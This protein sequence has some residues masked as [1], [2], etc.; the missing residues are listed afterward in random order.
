MLE[1]P[2]DVIKNSCRVFVYTRL[3]IYFNI[4]IFIFIVTGGTD[5]RPKEQ[6]PNRG[7]DPFDNGPTHHVPVKPT[8]PSSGNS[9]NVLI[10]NTS[11]ED[12]T[13]SFFAQ[14]GILAGMFFI[15]F[16]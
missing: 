11:N 3:D 2:S 10:M 7:S 1:L 13:T 9:D 14:P 16:L 8:D 5:S 6:F 12:R 15:K 4:K